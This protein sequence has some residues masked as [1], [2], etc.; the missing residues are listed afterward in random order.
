MS[1][2]VYRIAPS[3]LHSVLK[4]IVAASSRILAAAPVDGF[5][6]ALRKRIGVRHKLTATTS[7]GWP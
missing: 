2:V 3:Q 5:V 1:H 6:G 4:Q 7:P